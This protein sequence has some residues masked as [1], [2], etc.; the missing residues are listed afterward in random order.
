V[1]QFIGIVPA[2]AVNYVLN[3]YW[4]FQRMPR[5]DKR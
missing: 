1:H 2:T 5:P 3:S 4:T